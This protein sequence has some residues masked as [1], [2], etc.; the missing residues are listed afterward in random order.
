MLRHM[1][2]D[3]KTCDKITFYIY[4]YLGI[5]TYGKVDILFQRQLCTYIDIILYISYIY[6]YIYFD[7]K[8]YKVNIVN[9]IYILK[10]RAINIYIY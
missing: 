5:M 8:K 9:T 10:H 7:I 3:I 6:I 4:I 2:F 1:Y